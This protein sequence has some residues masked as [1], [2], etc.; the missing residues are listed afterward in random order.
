MKLIT[1]INR[2]EVCDQSA[3]SPLQIHYIHVSNPANDNVRV[4]ISAIIDNYTGS[5]DLE[6]VMERCSSREALDTCV[7]FTKVKPLN[8]CAF[9]MMKNMAWTKV[10]ESIDHFTCPVTKRVEILVN[11]TSFDMNLFSIF[12]IEK[13]Y[14]K[15]QAA[16]Y[17]GKEYITLCL[18]A[19][20]VKVITRYDRIEVCDQSAKSPMTVHY[21]R[22]SYP[23]N[24]SVRISAKAGIGNYKGYIDLECNV[25]RCASREAL[26]TCAPFTKLKPMNTCALLMM[27]NMAWTKI[28]ESIKP[29]FQCPL[30]GRVELSIDE[31]T[32]DSDLFRFFPL[33][34]Y[35]WKVAIRI[36]FGKEYTTVCSEGRVIKLA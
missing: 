1:R 25:Q 26:D 15:Q 9:V 31:V 11:D 5:I 10:V 27:K 2:M 22:L 24:E 8:T 12:P 14:W 4:S 36:Y 20:L 29:P 32:F 33:D 28:I 35:Y 3:A 6:C 17:F 30:T 21:I 7:P 19:N 34:N 13:Y 16:I 18:E 23:V